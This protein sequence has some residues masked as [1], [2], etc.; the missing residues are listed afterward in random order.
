M[1]PPKYPHE[2]NSGSPGEKCLPGTA[3]K[4]FIF[5]FKFNTGYMGTE[6]DN[7]CAYGHP[8][9]RTAMM[10]ATSNTRSSTTDPK[11]GNP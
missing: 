1:F 3:Q 10:G 6:L 2:N 11:I 4:I 7:I 9:K 8:R 5:N